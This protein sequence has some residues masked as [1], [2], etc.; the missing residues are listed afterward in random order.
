VRGFC[1]L[2]AFLLLTV[3]PDV[4]ATDKAEARLIYRRVIDSISIEGNHAVSDADVKRRMYSRTRSMWL[5]VKGDRR[6]RIQRE[7]LNRDTLEIK[8]LYLSLGYLKVG[9]KESFELRLPDSTALVKVEIAEGPRFHYSESRVTGTFPSDLWGRI[10]PIR[11]RF[12]PGAPVNPFAL[13]TAEIDIKTVM[14]NNGYPYAAVTHAVDT[15]G[16]PDQSLHHSLRFTGALRRR[17]HQRF[18]QL[19]GIRCPPGAE[20]HPRQCL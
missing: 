1:C 3:V 13:K 10:N 14:A 4:A 19:P 7:T 8:Y 15:T 2:A 11:S 20:D 9:I 18:R 16:S 12:R 5:A 6:S 17:A